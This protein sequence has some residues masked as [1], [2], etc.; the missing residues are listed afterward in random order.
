MLGI[1][2][3]L[4]RMAVIFGALWAGWKSSFRLIP[5][6]I[7]RG[8]LSRER[9]IALGHRWWLLIVLLVAILPTYPGGTWLNLTLGIAVFYILG[10][11]ASSVWAH[12]LAPCP[13]CIA[14]WPLDPAERAEDS[15]KLLWW[16][17]Y[18]RLIG[19]LMAIAVIASVGYFALPNILNAIAI[20][21]MIAADER[22]RMRHSALAPWCPWCGP[23]DDGGDDEAVS[24]E[25]DP[26][27]AHR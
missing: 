21:A 2:I 8:Y 24:P 27:G 4:S 9:F 23:D 11:H 15:A 1:V 17:H 16:R 14:S 25:P 12:D 10:L 6:L 7:T 13:Q 3:S 20:L 19:R 26:A 22:A 5:A 18:G